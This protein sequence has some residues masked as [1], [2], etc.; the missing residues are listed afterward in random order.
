[1]STEQNRNEPAAR[2]QTGSVEKEQRMEEIRDCLLMFQ[3]ARAIRAAMMAKWGVNRDTVNADIRR[4]WNELQSM[5][6]ARREQLYKRS[7]ARRQRMLALAIQE[8]KPLVREKIVELPATG[9]D[10]RRSR[11]VELTRENVIAPA[12]IRTAM[13]AGLDLD[14]LTGI[15]GPAANDKPIGIDVKFPV[16]V[17]NPPVHPEAAAPSDGAE[18]EEPEAPAAVPA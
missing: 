4:V 9:P 11:R 8:C 12:R 16:W 1:M 14:K 15:E 18:P 2:R 13:K 7:V 17:G 10:G 5:S 3:P 6:A